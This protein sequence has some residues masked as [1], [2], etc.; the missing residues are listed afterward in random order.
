MCSLATVVGCVSLALAAPDEEP[1]HRSIVAR[2]P[3]E[4]EGNLLYLTGRAGASRPLTLLLETGAGMTALHSPLA[5][6][7][8]VEITATVPGGGAGERQIDVR[9]GSL[10][11][12]EV[13]D[14]HVEDM[15]V[16]FMPLDHLWEYAG[17]RFDGL[18]GQDFLRR[19]AVEIGYAAGELRLHDPE[20]FEYSGTG[21]KLTFTSWMNLILVD[22]SVVQPGIDPVPGRFV[23]DTGAG[24]LAALVLSAP[25]VS[26]HGL[27]RPGQPFLS[28]PVAGQGIGGAVAA[29]IGRVSELRL[30][31]LVLRQPITTFTRDGGGFFATADCAGVIGNETLRRFRFFIDYERNEVVLEPN[32][33]LG[34]T[35]D[36]DTSGMT[37][38]MEGAD[39]DV[40]RVAI[41]LEGSPAAEAGVMP[42]DVLLEIDGR[43]VSKLALIGEILRA[44]GRYELLLRR[45]DQVLKAQ[46]ATRNLI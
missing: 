24:D 1:V 29:D 9:L 45:G 23:L 34:E 36:Y 32:A 4:S 44:P 5:E 8:G 18:L 39:L 3:F 21:Q 26:E 7:L 12:L 33:A 15:T 20:R 13:G 43:P 19:Y 31:D 16:S 46:I 28:P 42:G 30:G 40:A 17:R 22:A 25:F 11:S 38:L 37:V 27:R 14:A 35:F 2:V 41:V 6:E 10:G